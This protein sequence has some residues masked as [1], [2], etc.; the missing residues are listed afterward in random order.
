MSDFDNNP[1]ADPDLNNPFKVKKGGEE[2]A[3]TPGPPTSRSYKCTCKLSRLSLRVKHCPTPFSHPPRSLKLWPLPVKQDWLVGG[4]AEAFL[5]GFKLAAR[6]PIAGTAG[7]VGGA[8]RPSKRRRRPG[9][10][11]EERP[12]PTAGVEYLMQPSLTQTLLLA[13]P[14]VKQDKNMREYSGVDPSVTQVTR[15]VPPGLDEY[16]PF[17]DS[18]T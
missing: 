14:R 18:R 1:F 8:L 11:W 3:G 9:R 2:G 5:L 4:P 12:T 16:N 15:N 17:S 7:H 13:A 10:P 6:G